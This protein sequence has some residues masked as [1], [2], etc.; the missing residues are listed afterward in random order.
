MSPS[1][2]RAPWSRAPPVR[3]GGRARCPHRAAA[4]SARCAAW[5]RAPLCGPV[6]RSRCGRARCLAA[7]PPGSRRRAASPAVA[8]RRGA[9]LG[10]PHTL[11][12]LRGASPCAPYRLPGLPARAGRGVCPPPGRRRPHRFSIPHRFPS[13]RAPPRIYTYFT[14]LLFWFLHRISILRCIANPRKTLRSSLPFRCLD[15]A[16]KN[17]NRLATGERPLFKQIHQ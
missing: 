17:R 8:H 7:G 2:R 12:V 14:A 16:C 15:C 10:F 1:R 6:V 4:P 13:P 3:L 11:R 9:R 5:H